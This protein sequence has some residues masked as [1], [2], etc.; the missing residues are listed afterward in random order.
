[1]ADSFSLPN[2]IR[3]GAMSLA[4]S[5][6]SP[7]AKA[8][9]NR[10]Y[11]IGHPC[12]RYLYLKRTAGDQAKP[13]PPSL[14]GIFYTGSLVHEV[15]FKNLMDIGSATGLFDVTSREVPLDWVKYRITGHIDGMLVDRDTRQPICG[16][17]IK[18]VGQKFDSL[19]TLEDLMG[20]RYSR[21]WVGQGTSYMLL[22]EVPRFANV[23][24]R[25]N[26]LLDIKVIEYDLDFDL[27]ESLIGKAEI[28]NAAVDAGDPEKAPKIN[29]P[30]WCIDCPLAHICM[31]EIHIPEGG[32]IEAEEA[33]EAVERMFQ[34][35]PSVSEYD[36]CKR[37]VDKYVKPALGPADGMAGTVKTLA[38]GMY[39]KF[40]KGTKRHEAA[41]AERDT[42]YWR[43]INAAEPP[44]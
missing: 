38:V 39:Q 36:A 5:R 7:P 31:P 8:A 1:M 40:F 24:V 14:A 43:E 19:N 23:L 34:L 33:I 18:S 12:H 17:D 37:L 41:R 35:K 9:S 4:M 21:L 13:I 32:H 42:F 29:D 16:F 28:V 27:G 3:E 2:A 22:T 10:S 30:E 15:T 20:W 25:K 11:E 44:E 26:N 6:T